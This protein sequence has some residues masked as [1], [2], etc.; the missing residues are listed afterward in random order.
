[1][2]LPRGSV[3]RPSALTV[4]SVR[5]DQ[6]SLILSTL[7]MSRSPRHA[8]SLYSAVHRATSLPLPGA[9]GAKPMLGLGAGARLLSRE[10]G[11]GKGPGDEKVVLAA[12][13]TTGGDGTA[14]MGA[15]A[16]A[17]MRPAAMQGALQLR[18]NVRR[19]EAEL[20]T[21]STSIALSSGASG[22][23]VIGAHGL[24]GHAAGAPGGDEEMGLHAGQDAESNGSDSETE[25]REEEE[26]EELLEGMPVSEA[27]RNAV[28]VLER[29]LPRARPGSGAVRGWLVGDLYA[30]LA[31]VS[32][33]AW[34]AWHVPEGQ[35]V[36]VGMLQLM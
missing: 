29:P 11:T 17:Q 19:T 5:L 1:M 30:T 15:A 12:Q 10:I 4:N 6:S 25:G 35:M 13:H 36:E 2:G 26:E 32:H 33:H 9:G 31:M 23:G 14:S 3:G 34:E 28:F 16:N 27:A 20:L 18:R 7:S 22:H 8:G 24:R 21:S